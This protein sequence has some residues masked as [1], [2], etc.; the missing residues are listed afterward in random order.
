M[1]LPIILGIT[2]SRL[3]ASS[4]F[5]VLQYIQVCILITS[6]SQFIF[7][8]HIGQFNIIPHLFHKL[9]KCFVDN[10]F[11]ISDLP[12]HIRRRGADFLSKF[13]LSDTAFYALYLHFDFNIILKHDY[14]PHIAVTY[15]ITKLHFIIANNYELFYPSCAKNTP[16]NQPPNVRILKEAE[17]NDGSAKKGTH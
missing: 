13:C 9:Q 3:N 17:M 8:F 2:C 12:T 5:S 1:Y 16:S 11:V 14:C 4:S 7:P 15:I 6:L 10:L